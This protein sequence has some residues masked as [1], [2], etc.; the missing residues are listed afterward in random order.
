M[1]YDVIVVGGGMAGLTAAAYLCRAGRSVLLCEKEGRLGG[2]VGSFRHNGFVFD[3]GIR[4]LENS[5]VLF[6]M[7]RQLGLHVD[8]VRSGVTIG[9]GDAR[10]NL[11]SPESIHAYQ[12]MLTDQFPREAQALDAFIG[13]VKKAMGFMD[14]LYG[15]DNP[16]FL[17]NMK[18]PVYLRKTLLPWM[19]R[20]ARNIGKIK[21]FS[22][23]VEE[24][25]G[26]IISNPAL[27]DV[28][29]QHFFKRTP[30]FFALSYFSLYLDY[31]YPIGGTGKL[32]DAME[33][34]IRGHGGEIRTSTEIKAVDTARRSVED[35][36]GNTIE[37]R[38]LVWCAD[39]KA[40]YHSLQRLELLPDKTRESLAA[41]RAFLQDKEG[42]D[43][44]LTLYLETGLDKDYFTQRHSPHFFQ[45]PSKLGLGAVRTGIRDGGGGYTKDRETVF[46]YLR[47]YLTLT[48]FEISIPAL[49][50]ADLAP[51]G[52]TGLIISTL[53]DY[54][55]VR[56]IEDE[57]WYDAFKALCRETICAVLTDSVYP[58]LGDKIDDGFVSSPLT[59]MRRTGNTGGAITGWAF[60]N[61][62]MP[63]VSS[64]PSIAKSVR[65]PIPGVLQAG[66]WS[67][68]P[69]GMPVSILTGK[70]AADRALKELRH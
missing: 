22:M 33:G 14:V 40:L 35:A 48:T 7:L 59:L 41:R 8:F 15:I 53:M 31:A 23:P 4:A 10:V 5:G 68:S 50:D 36:G 39:Q 64:M 43:S 54:A 42:G 11:D 2:L 57:G 44:V 69:S 70:L 16:L 65:T 66:Q 63:A 19:L 20:Y 28:L 24:C 46:A 34:Y 1:T 38:R 47:E 21:R 29:A 51:P 25:L 55:L 3:A 12:Q 32:V 61:S 60:T 13:L 49:R 56:H 30:A 26:A 6:P 58:G 62:A 45:T 52:K 18:D 27:I 67:F 37:Y 9:V 17:D